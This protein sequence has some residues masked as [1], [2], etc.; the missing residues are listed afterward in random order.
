M[1][2]E[3]RLEM[4]DPN[5]L[6][7]PSTSSVSGGHGPSFPTH[8]PTHKM[9]GPVRLPRTRAV[10]AVVYTVEV[11]SSRVSVRACRISHWQEHRKPCCKTTRDNESAGRYKLSLRRQPHLS[12]LSRVLAAGR[13]RGFTH[14]RGKAWVAAKRFQVIVGLQVFCIA[15]PKVNGFP[16][17]L[18]GL[19]RTVR[20]YCHAGIVVPSRPKRSPLAPAYLFDGVGEQLLHFV[21]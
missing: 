19:V 13:F 21:T 11:S 2:T 4:V 10:P 8:N 15:V 5:G 1:K 17:I 12:P 16:Q 20:H 9:R 6:D 18:K 7:P 14:Q 3:Q